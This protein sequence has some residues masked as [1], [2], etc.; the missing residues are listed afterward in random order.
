MSVSSKSMRVS[1]LVVL[2]AGLAVAVVRA[3]GDAR[4]VDCLPDLGPEQDRASNEVPH[5]GS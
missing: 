2:V 5:E 4:R 1:Q 3:Q